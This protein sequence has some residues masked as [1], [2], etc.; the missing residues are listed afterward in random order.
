MVLNENEWSAVA[1]KFRSSKEVRQVVNRG[2]VARGKSRFILVQVVPALGIPIF[3]AT[4]ITD[5]YHHLFRIGAL[6]EHG[7]LPI[8]FIICLIGGYVFGLWRWHRFVRRELV[9]LCAF[10]MPLLSI[11]SQAQNHNELRTPLGSGREGNAWIEQTLKQLSL[12]EKVGQMLQIRV[13]GDYQDLAGPEY[14]IV[15]GEIQKY[16]VGSIDLGARMSGPN[17]VKGTPVQV[18]T[19]LNQLQ[20]GSKLPLLVGADIERGLASRL[21]K[22]P[23]F[24]FPMAFGAIADSGIAERFGAITAKEAR[25]VGIHWAYAPVADVN[26][27]PMNPIINTRSFG[28]DPGSVADMVGAYIRGAHQNGLL[29]AVKHF[30]GEGDTSNDPH[31]GVTR[32]EANRRHLEQYE[33]P[34]F[35]RAIQAGA[36]SVMVAQVSAPELDSDPTKVATTS[37]KIIDG[38][39]RKDLGFHG[40]VITDALEMRG[41]TRLYP[42]EVNP[43]GRIAV[44]AV[45]AGNDVL[46]LPRDID[47]A[48]TAIVDAVRNGEIPESRIDESVRRILQMKAALGL[49]ESR[50]VDLNRLQSIFG[51]TEASE[52]AQQVSDS[53]ITLVRNNRYVLPLL[54]KNPQT[55][56]KIHNLDSASRKL[57]VIIFA[58]SHNSRLGPTFEKELKSRRPDAQVFHYYNDHIGSDAL[59]TEVI[60]AVKAADEVVLAA[61]ITHA[62]GRQIPSRGIAVSAV[63]LSGEGAQFFGDM[64]TVGLEKTVVIALGSPYF[65]QSYPQTQNYICTYSLTPTAEVSAVRALFGDIQNHA[66]LPVTLPGV[67]NRGFSL[68]WPQKKPGLQAHAQ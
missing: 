43:S 47:A 30:P 45:K 11:I 55:A 51:G 23:E 3:V 9:V 16:H 19:V 37:P 58:D 26:S 29:V 1:L 68:P 5:R 61:F 20:R 25:S 42:Q 35:K 53:A 13:Y 34:P 2:F 64:V 21:S 22:T 17:L 46:M 59:P 66:T 7:W 57:V 32:I 12:E 50:Y 39:L 14:T 48:F 65:I 10:F 67:A 41:L 62:P 18:A 40:V 60:P 27:D 52:F 49:N 6:W 15:R 31:V 38:T 54:D 28:E 24:P 36:D 33:F 44:D 8:N 63:G 56:Q 4:T